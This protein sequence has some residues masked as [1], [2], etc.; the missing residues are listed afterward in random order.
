MNLVQSLVCLTLAAGLI[1]A[2]FASADRARA[3]ISGLVLIVLFIA[4]SALPLDRSL[5]MGDYGTYTASRQNFD[6][7]MGKDAVRFEAHLSTTAL[8]L[9]DR[10]LGATEETPA[11]AFDVLC[12]LAAAWYTAMLLV[13]TWA[14]GWSPAA[15]RYAG[16]SLA[17]PATLMYFG[18]RELGYLSLNAAAFPLIASGL[19]GARWR[20][21][22]G[23]ALSGLGAALH[24][25]GLLALVG[26]A[27][28]AAASPLRGSERVRFVLHA[29]AVGTSA[30]LIWVFVYIVGLGLTVVPG[31]AG[32]VPWRPLFIST[33]AEHRVNHAIVSSRGAA[34]ILATSWIAGMPLLALV[35]AAFRRGTTDAIP[36]LAYVLPSIV[37]VCAFWPVQG[38][39][40]DGD[41]IFAAFPAVYA[42]I[43][44]AAQRLSTTWMALLL[45]ATGHIVFWRVMLSD[46][47]VN[48]RVY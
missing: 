20:F 44:L 36:V 32:S 39:A 40:V 35:P 15:L 30:Y 27:A 1:A 42:L 12:E 16:L 48:S 10:S 34:E 13:A 7:Y 14:A 18:Y 33:L 6:T 8:R 47:F 17:A 4:A 41:L 9:I 22:A 2:S 38:I 29:F 24:G 37:F 43:W 5:R 19:K 28:A 23:C 25:F 45:L 31:H 11:A 26:A 46:A 21:D 3:W